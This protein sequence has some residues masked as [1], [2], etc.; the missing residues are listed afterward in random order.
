MTSFFAALTDRQ[1]SASLRSWLNPKKPTTLLHAWD[2]N[3]RRASAIVVLS[4]PHFDFE[5]N[6]CVCVCERGKGGEGRHALDLRGQER[7]HEIKH[8]VTYTAHIPHPTRRPHP[9]ASAEHTKPTIHIPNAVPLTISSSTGPSSIP[10]NAL[11]FPVGVDDPLA[12]AEAA[13]GVLDL[14]NPNLPKKLFPVGVLGVVTACP[15][16]LV[17]LTESEEL[18][19]E[20]LS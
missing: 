6:K 2:G 8:P 7:Q 18:L 11:P 3:G 5:R 10:S 4:L 17:E 20:L 14:L 19:F 16:L 1:R 9:S 15:C 13:T 12:G